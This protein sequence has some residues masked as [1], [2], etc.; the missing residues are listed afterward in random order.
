MFI[1]TDTDNYVSNINDTARH[2]HRGSNLNKTEIK[3]V[4][5]GNK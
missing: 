3:M 1:E 2:R 5:T 4:K